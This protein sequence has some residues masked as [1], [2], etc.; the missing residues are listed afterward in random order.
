MLTDRVPGADV[1]CPT[2]KDYPIMLRE[3]NPHAGAVDVGSENF[4]AAVYGG[5]VQVFGT[6]TRDLQ[7]VL[8]FFKNN[9][10]NSAA[11]EATGVYWMPLYEMLKKGGLKVCMVNGAHVKN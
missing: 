5:P 10:V 2:T 3:I 9:G 8:E 6:F 11:M 4:Y 7:Q 1:L